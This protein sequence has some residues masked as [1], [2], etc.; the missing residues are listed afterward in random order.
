M[1]VLIIPEDQELDRYIVKP[2]VEA[3]FADLGVPASV[4][5]LPE[6]R[7]RGA[8][9]ALDKDTVASIVRDNP[10]EDLFL[11]IVDR[12]CNREQ[13]EAKAAQRL[14]EHAGK[15]LACL[16]V[17]E[18]EVWLLALYKDRLKVTFT[19]VRK[20]PDPKERWAE[21]LL[22]ELGSEGPGRGRKAAMRALSG[23]WRSLHDT[24]PELLDLQRR[25][26]AWQQQ[27]APV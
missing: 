17:Q 12:D 21:P 26:Q 19:E 20:D 4:N 23:K 24:C 3:L 10:M 14:A 16:A 15:L 9:E 1:K 6:P 18:V 7:L 11:L 2:V 22:K 8:G 5:V 27:P 13:H 25:I